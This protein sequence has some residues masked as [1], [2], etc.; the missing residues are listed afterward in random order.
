MVSS[1][2]ARVSRAYCAENNR[3][4]VIHGNSSACAHLS[5]FSVNGVYDAPGGVQPSV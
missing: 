4:S 1:M 2:P 3:A 5:G